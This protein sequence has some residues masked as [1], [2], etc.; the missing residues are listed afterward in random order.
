MPRLRIANRWASHSCALATVST[1]ARR[2]LLATDV[3]HVIRP[4]ALREKI[5]EHLRPDVARSPQSI[6]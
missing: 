1:M 6:S 2:L 5:L 4:D 3:D